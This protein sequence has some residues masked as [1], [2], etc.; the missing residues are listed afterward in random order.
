MVNSMA[1]YIEKILTFLNNIPADKKAHSLGGLII[2]NFLNFFIFHIFSLVIVIIIAIGKEVYDGTKEN[3]TKDKW[4]A[5]A[6][7]IIPAIL[8]SI[9]LLLGF[10]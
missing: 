5:F 8:S 2:Y 3:H 9:T 7:A 6:T 10:I 1:S 4:D